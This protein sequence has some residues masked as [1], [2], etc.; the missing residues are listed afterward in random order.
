MTQAALDTGIPVILGY[1]TT[2]NEEQAE[3]RAGGSVGNKGY[4]A[5]LTGIEMANL[6]KTLGNTER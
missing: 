2:E 6:M 5:A 1:L 4:D 3:A